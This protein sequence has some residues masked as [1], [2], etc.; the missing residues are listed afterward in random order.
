[1]DKLTG[2]DSDPGFFGLLHGR[3]NLLAVVLQFFL[4]EYGRGQSKLLDKSS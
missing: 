2:A 3:N 1:M 4:K